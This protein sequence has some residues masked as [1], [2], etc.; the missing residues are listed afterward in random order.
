MSVSRMI[1]PISAPKAM[2][3]I[4]SVSTATV[5]SGRDCRCVENPL[6]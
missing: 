6:P 2:V 3:S 4:S 5:M 1:Q